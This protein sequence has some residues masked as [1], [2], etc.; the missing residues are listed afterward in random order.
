MFV[1]GPAVMYSAILLWSR[2][3]VSGVHCYRRW[4]MG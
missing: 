4:N 2:T 3:A 1:V